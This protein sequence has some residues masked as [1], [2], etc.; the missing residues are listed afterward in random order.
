MNYI[1]SANATAALKV[2]KL[3]SILPF[4]SIRSCSEQVQFT[5]SPLR[6]S[7]ESAP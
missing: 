2:F 7:K 4:R 6:S 5:R 1:E 3:F